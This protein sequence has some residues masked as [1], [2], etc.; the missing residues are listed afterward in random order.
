MYRVDATKNR[1]FDGSMA[2]KLLGHYDELDNRL[3]QLGV[4]DPRDN[5]PLQDH[6]R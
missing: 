5:Q 4:E 2:P 1:T 6:L 3:P